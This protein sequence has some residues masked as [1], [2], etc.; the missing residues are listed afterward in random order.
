[1]NTR[2]FSKAKVGGGHLF[3]LLITLLLVFGMVSPQAP[4]SAYAE[5]GD[6]ADDGVDPIGDLDWEAPLDGFTWEMAQRYGPDRNLD[7]MVDTFWLSD[8]Q[9]YAPTY[10]FPAYWTVRFEGC[11]TQPDAQSPNATWNSYTWQIVGQ[12]TPFASGYKCA[13][14]YNFPAQGAYTVRLTVHDR[15]GNIVPA[16]KT[17][18]EY[19]QQ[20]VTIRDILIVALGDSYGSGEGSPDIIQTYHSLFPLPG[21][22]LDSQAVWQDE[23]CHRSAY[24]GSS[25]AAIALENADPH[26][27]VTYISFACSGATLQAETWKD[28]DPNQP[29]GSGVLGAYWGAVDVGVLFSQDH[30]TPPY[31]AGYIKP[32]IVALEEALIPPAGRPAR[33]VDALIISGGG[34]DIHFFD[35]LAAC[36]LAPDCWD[37]SIKMPEDPYNTTWYTMENIIQRALGH[38]GDAGPAITLP[39]SY[40]E[41]DRRLDQLQPAPPAHVYLTQ[42]PNQTRDRSGAVCETMLED[43]FVPNYLSL[44]ISRDEAREAVSRGLGPLND[45]VREAAGR[46]GWQLVDGLASYDVD[47]TVSDKPQPGLFVTGHDGQ[48]HGYCAENNWIVRAEE[49]ELSQGPLNLRVLSKGTMHPNRDG[50]RTIRERLLRYMIPDLIAQPQAAPAFSLSYSLDGYTDV[51]SATGWYLQSCSGSVCQPKVVAQAVATSAVSLVGAEVSAN[52]VVGC[53]IAGVSCTI[54]ERDD[55]HQVTYRVEITAS[56]TYSFRFVAQDSSGQIS[57]LEQ[58]I[59]VDLEDPVLATPIGPFQ[60]EEGGSVVLSASVATDANGVPLNNDVVVDFNWDLDNDGIFETL[61]E[62]PSFSAADIDGPMTQYIRVRVT[63]RAGR[64]ATGQAA[65][66]VLNVGPTAVINGAPP[67][68]SEGTAINLSSSVTDPGVDDTFYYTWTVKKNGASY[69]SGTIAGFSFTPDDNGSYQVSL[70]VEDDDDG[71]CT[72]SQTI[73]VTNVAPALSNVTVSPGTVN[74]GGS[75][76]LAGSISDA[77]SADAFNLTIDWRDGSA[78]ELVSL[79]AG[80]TSFSRNHTYADDNPSGTAWDTYVIAL[81]IADDDGGTD[82]GS[83]SVTVNNLAPSLSISAP[84]TGALYAVNVAIALSASLADPSSLDTLTCSV[85]WDDGTTGSGTVAAGVC[86]ASHA[87][88]AAGVYNI[89]ITGTDDDTGAKTASVMVVVYDPSAGF[90]TGGGWINSPAGAYKAD[91]SLSGKATFGFVSKYQKGTSVPTGNTAFQFQAGD[92]TFQSTAYQW[93][94]VDKAGAN[95]QFKGS[96]TVNGGLD[97]NGNEYKFMLWATD[98][99]PDTFRIKIW[100]EDGADE[101]VVYDNGFDQDIGGGSIVVH[102]K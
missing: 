89:E 14:Q 90:V 66:N 6:D 5:I 22:W 62:Q 17:N 20:E 35:I 57:S 67:S 100:W 71:V 98:G 54:P 61:D 95:A 10:I 13:V 46:H 102:T 18:P 75:V 8:Q 85:N 65:V 25:L 96:G 97:P 30:D 69:A 36:F 23:R 42:Y 33:Q 83:A 64:T 28:W 80:S 43:I 56:G 79:P 76:T 87:Y 31:Y 53:A 52:G 93:L 99:V 78:P 51:A 44:Y 68:S 11:Q 41:L 72:T 84:E 82:T 94:V 92:F 3:L 7:R 60:V 47:P 58:E 32:Q 1:M 12:S 2:K 49:A 16:G 4:Q 101:H 77:G 34:N 21:W 19:F 26:T 15:S 86:T 63:D 38:W 91:A 24:S 59:K 9:K 39:A 55:Q 81:T 88:T 48:G 50:N 29:L 37:P 27:S 40:D 45:H 73:D 70:R 74:E